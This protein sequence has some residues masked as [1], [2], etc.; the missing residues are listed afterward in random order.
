MLFQGDL[1]PSEHER[2]S[3]LHQQQ[4][5]HHHHR[6]CK[7]KLHVS[8]Q[9]HC[10]DFNCAKNRKKNV[11]VVCTLLLLLLLLSPTFLSFLSCLTFSTLSFVFLLFFFGSQTTEVGSS[12]PPNKDLMNLRVLG[13]KKGAQQEAA[14]WPW[15]SRFNIL[16]LWVKH[17]WQMHSWY[18]YLEVVH[19]WNGAAFQSM[20]TS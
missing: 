20:K 13:T 5:S 6:V 10:K 14:W 9:G 7:W 15:S 2:R 8:T 3:V 11:C 19:V 12:E 4:R 18:C 17:L 16:V 1:S